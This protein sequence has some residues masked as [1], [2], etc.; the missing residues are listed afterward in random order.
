MYNTPIMTAVENY[1]NSDCARMHMPGHKGNM[2]GFLKEAAK[3]DLTE[4]S[5]T[6]NLYDPKD[7]IL[8]CEEEY[9]KIYGSE[10]SIICAGGS[11]LCI[12]TMLTIIAKENAKIIAGR[13]IHISAVNAMGLLGIEPVWVYPEGNSGKGMPGIIS[14]EKIENAILE[15]EDICAVYITTPDYFGV[16]SD[17]KAISEICHKHNVPLLVDNAHGA[18]LKFYEKSCHP[19]DL[20]ADMCNDSLHKTLPILTSGAVLHIASKE[21][22]KK[23][24]EC[25]SMFGTTSPSYLILE[26]IDLALDYLKNDVAEDCKKLEKWVK[27]AKKLA[28]EKGFDVPTG[29]CE[30]S[31]LVLG[32]APLGY[33]SED[34][35]CEL[36]KYNIEHEYMSDTH[37]VLMPSVFNSDDELNRVLKLIENI[38]PIGES[39]EFSSTFV[40]PKSVMS[41]RKAMFSPKEIIDVSDSLGRISASVKSKCPPGIPLLIPGEIIDDKV[42]KILKKYGILKVTVV[43][44]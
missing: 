27:A 2:Q 8:K 40:E 1:I 33:T 9:A 38:T 32:F 37:C 10:R 20:G 21:F 17:V 3:Y 31:K 12:Q 39:I 41:I 44:C 4:I 11:T 13:N 26:S 19:M 5:C 30:Y 18:T 34:F 7:C 22:A 24:K 36:K 16:L 29:N 43:Q 42:I 25:M 28:V 14:P 23:A 35:R 6:D 15:N